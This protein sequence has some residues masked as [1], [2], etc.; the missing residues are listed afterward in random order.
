MQIYPTE[1]NNTIRGAMRRSGWR[2]RLANHV[3][4]ITARGSGLP[5]LYSNPCQPDSR[6]NSSHRTLLKS[7]SR[8]VDGDLYLSERRCARSSNGV[9]NRAGPRIQAS[10]AGLPMK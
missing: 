3:M 8:A 6:P 5:R 1:I 2:A 10:Q 7:Q 4:R 9:R